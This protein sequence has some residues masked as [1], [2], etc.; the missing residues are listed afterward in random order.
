MAAVE[1][2]SW[3]TVFTAV[4]AAVFGWQIWS[5][6]RARWLHDLHKIPGPTSLPVIG[7]APQ[8]FMRSIH[9][10]SL[11]SPADTQLRSGRQVH[12]NALLNVTAVTQNYARWAKQFGSI[13][14]F[15]ILSDVFVVISDPQ[16]VLR[17]TSRQEDVPK[18]HEGY[19]TIKQ[20]RPACSPCIA[21][22]SGS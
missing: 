4:L 3:P 8:L 6:I 5:R 17:L 22:A 9:I 10:V 12:C 14:K 11:A 21:Q 16:E 7:N 20:V 2:P 15:S 1:M 19:R 13:Y 18:W